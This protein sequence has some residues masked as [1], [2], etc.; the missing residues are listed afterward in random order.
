M[1][2]IYFECCSLYGGSWQKINR[3]L[4]RIYGLKKTEIVWN[5]CSQDLPER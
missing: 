3:N 5:F 1:E 4:I 2:Y